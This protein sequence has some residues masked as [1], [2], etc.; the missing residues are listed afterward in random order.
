MVQITR[1]LC[2]QVFMVKRAFFFRLLLFRLQ[3]CSCSCF[4]KDISSY[5]QTSTIPR[6]SK[7]FFFLAAAVLF[8]D[9]F[10]QV[11]FDAAPPDSLASWHGGAI[12]SFCFGFRPSSLL[13]MISFDLGSLFLWWCMFLVVGVWRLGFGSPPPVYFDRTRYARLATFEGTLPCFQSIATA[14]VLMPGS[15]CISRWRRSNRNLYC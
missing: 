5:W 15:L 6:G 12:R 8:I 7:V 1:L 13:A 4:S 3:L 9:S 10:H 2:K 11:V 14:I